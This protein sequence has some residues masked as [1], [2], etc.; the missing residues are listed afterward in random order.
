M[1]TVLIPRERA[2]AQACCGPAP[3]NVASTCCVTSYPRICVSARIGRHIASFATWMNPYATSSAL[4]GASAGRSALIVPAMACIAAFVA[5]SSSGSFWSF[6][7][8]FGKTSGSTRPSCTLA[9][10]TASQPFLR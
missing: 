5:V 3:P 1:K 6:P 2:I 10:V 9:S 4:M 8:I 7:K